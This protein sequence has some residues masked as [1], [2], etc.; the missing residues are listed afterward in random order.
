MLAGAYPDRISFRTFYPALL[1]L[2]IVEHTVGG[3]SV[4]ANDVNRFFSIL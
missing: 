4:V 2:G 1:R 3:L